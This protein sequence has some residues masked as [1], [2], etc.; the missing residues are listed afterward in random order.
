MIG[1]GVPP[2]KTIKWIFV[3]TQSIS[4]RLC[5]W[6]FKRFY[7]YREGMLNG[8]KSD[9]CRR[10]MNWYKIFFAYFSNLL[11]Y[12]SRTTT[13]K[14]GWG[15]QDTCQW[16]VDQVVI[17]TNRSDKTEIKKNYKSA[18]TSRGG[19][20][21]F[22][23]PFSYPQL[24][25]WPL[26]CIDKYVYTFYRISNFALSIAILELEVAPLTGAGE[27]RPWYGAGKGKA[28]SMAWKP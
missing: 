20:V 3:L 12:A 23:G 16:L 5:R 13:T 10:F 9:R 27:K 4:H 25:R 6:K 21:P 24:C 14:A 28:Y 26:I 17:R 2:I 18:A 22:Q 8:C 1:H 15:K 11:V 19:S 7:R